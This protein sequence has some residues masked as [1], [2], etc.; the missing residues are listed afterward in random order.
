VIDPLVC[1]L[2]VLGVAIVGSLGCVVI[3]GTQS[4]TPKPRGDTVRERPE[5]L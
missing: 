5:R 1:L 2:V 3:H 4:R